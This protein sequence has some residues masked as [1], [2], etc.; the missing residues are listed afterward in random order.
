MPRDMLITAVEAAYGSEEAKSYAFLNDAYG[1]DTRSE[2]RKKEPSER[3]TKIRTKK[4]KK[5][6]ST[7]YNIGDSVMVMP[8]KRIGIVCEPVNEKGVLR[9]QVAGK[10]IWINHKRVKL[11][12]R[13]EELYPE[14]YDFSIIFDSV[15][16]RKM[17]HDMGRKFVEGTLDYNEE[18]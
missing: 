2:K 5:N 14:D 15:E 3:I 17:R 4:S 7:L 6:L 9:V 12:V 13:A 8:D 1:N 10:K 11:H 16:Q 18:D